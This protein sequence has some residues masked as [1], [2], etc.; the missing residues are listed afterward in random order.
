[1]YKH[2]EE[3]QKRHTKMAKKVLKMISKEIDMPYH[4]VHRTFTDGEDTEINRKITVMFWTLLRQTYPEADTYRE[5]CFCHSCKKFDLYDE[6]TIKQYV[7]QQIKP[8][9]GWNL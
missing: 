8:F 9:N 1:M 3:H 5:V 7:Q 2:S 6:K 4:S